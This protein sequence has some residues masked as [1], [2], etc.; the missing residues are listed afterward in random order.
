M[1]AVHECNKLQGL[2]Q[3]LPQTSK[4]WSQNWNPP[5]GSKTKLAGKFNPIGRQFSVIPGDSELEVPGMS[6]C[7]MLAELGIAEEKGAGGLVQDP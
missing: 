5:L 4:V 6:S 3:K 1:L 2:G 7:L